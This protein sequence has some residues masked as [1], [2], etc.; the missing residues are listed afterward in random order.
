MHRPDAASRASMLRHC[1]VRPFI[2]YRVDASSSG[3]TDW[4]QIADR[5]RKNPAFN[6]VSLSLVW[7]DL[8]RPQEVALHPVTQGREHS[9]GLERCREGP[10]WASR[11]VTTIGMRCIGIRARDMLFDAEPG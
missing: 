3:I 10:V 2:Q 7:S 5:L 4:V 8:A 11:R 9:S 6:V 1:P